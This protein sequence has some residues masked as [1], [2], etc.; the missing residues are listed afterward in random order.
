MPT[1]ADSD[2]V[3][4]G[5]RKA[6]DTNAPD[7]AKKIK[8]SIDI[9]NNELIVF[10]P[11]MEIFESLSLHN[12][13][14]SVLDELFPK[15]KRTEKMTTEIE[16]L[17][18]SP[19]LNSAI[20]QIIAVN[21]LKTRARGGLIANLIPTV[22]GIVDVLGPLLGSNRHKR[23]TKAWSE[24]RPHIKGS[25]DYT[26]RHFNRVKLMSVDELDELINSSDCADSK[27]AIQLGLALLRVAI[28]VI[29]DGDEI[30]DSDE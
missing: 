12:D 11:P 5:K 17:L 25:T 4:K 6:D 28:S 1:K 15:E 30:Y 24:V 3:Q 10:Q 16:K 26:Q 29:K 14:V 9:E 8:K 13:A 18:T 22:D 21:I 7:I 19:D 20:S 27:Q 2:Q 23:I